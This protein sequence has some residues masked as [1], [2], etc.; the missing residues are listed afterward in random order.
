YRCACYNPTP[1]DYAAYELK[2]IQLLHRHGLRAVLMA[3]RIVW[4][5]A[6]ELIG[7]D[8]DLKTRMLEMVTAGPTEHD[9]LYQVTL[10]SN[11]EI[12]YTDDML[13]SDAEDVI[14]GLCKLS[15]EQA[16]QTED[17]TWWPRQLQWIG[18]GMDTGPWS[19]WNES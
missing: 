1:S 12:H 19:P 8:G 17:A 9:R 2:V 14:C 3:G 7:Y 15:T 5:I 10:I 6:T 4:R 18:S 13:S 16:K 11:G